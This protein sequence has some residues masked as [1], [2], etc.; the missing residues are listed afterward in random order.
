MPI[1]GVKIYTSLG[2]NLN[3]LHITFLIILFLR[4]ISTLLWTLRW[5]FLRNEPK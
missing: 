4:I 2:S 3:A 5:W 1:V